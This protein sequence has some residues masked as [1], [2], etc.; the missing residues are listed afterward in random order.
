[1]HHRSLLALLTAM[2]AIAGGRAHADDADD[3]AEVL[4]MQARLH[5]RVPA[6]MR[7]FTA[8]LGTDVTLQLRAAG[9]TPQQAAIRSGS[10][11]V[12]I[13]PSGLVG[14]PCPDAGIPIARFSLE[15]GLRAWFKARAIAQEQGADPVT[16]D[17]LGFSH[18]GASCEPGWRITLVVEDSLYLYLRF[19]V[20]GSLA[21]VSRL[22]AGRHS[23]LDTASVRAMDTRASAAL[24]SAR[25]EATPLPAE[26]EITLPTG[27]EYLVASIAGQAYVCAQED[28]AFVYDYHSIDLR[29]EG[30]STPDPLVLRVA[31]VAP[32]KSE[33][34]MIPSMAGPELWIRRGLI[35]LESDDE[36][37]DTHVW[38][39]ALDTHLIE[40]RFEGTLSNAS[41]KRV[42]I[43]DGR[44]RLLPEP[45]FRVTPP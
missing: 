34:R 14:T 15:S 10:D 13:K 32:G 12:E 19:D 9:S 17:R 45:G 30:D 25:A 37:L 31:G 38:V 3:L 26:A 21:S 40:G 20:D 36:L 29:C 28:I 4:R 7:V 11:W 1:M 16:L 5:E 39:D 23:E 43:T 8:E 44:F 22:D 41:G 33:H 18:E 6:G 42:R 2:A 27:A 35:E 24:P